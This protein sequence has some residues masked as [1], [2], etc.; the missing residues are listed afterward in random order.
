MAGL[1]CRQYLGC[2]LASALAGFTVLG[3]SYLLDA[4]EPWWS[5]LFAA[6]RTEAE[7]VELVLGDLVALFL[8]HRQGR[9]TE[10]SF[11]LR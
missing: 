3:G 2:G 5:C 11:Q 7:Q 1:A 6:L 10:R 4:R 9:L 8:G